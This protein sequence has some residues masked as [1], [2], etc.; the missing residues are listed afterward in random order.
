MIAEK[1]R[2]L[3]GKYNKYKKEFENISNTFHSFFESQNEK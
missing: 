3:R 1:G 2:K